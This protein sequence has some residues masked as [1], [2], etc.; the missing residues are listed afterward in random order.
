MPCRLAYRTRATTS[1]TEPGRSTAS[2]VRCTRWPKSS[3]AAESAAGSVVSS[4]SSSGTAT[5]PR[6]VPP[7][8]SA[9]VTQPARTGSNAT[10]AAPASAV[11]RKRRRSSEKDIELLRV[12]AG[13]RPPANTTRPSLP[14]RGRPDGRQRQP[15]HRLPEQG[16]HERLGLERSEVVGTLAEADQLHR[17]AELALHRDHDPALGGAVQLG[18]HD[19]G[20]VDGLGEDPGLDD[21]VLPGGGVEHE[22]GLVHR[23][24]LLDHPLDL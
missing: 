4:P 15:L 3:A 1:S 21:A 22:Q 8:A 9:T 17:H 2:G 10:I 18:Q 24:L 7:A 23:A 11:P 14:T 19:P 16:V 6:G 13:A 5:A 12:R 20:D